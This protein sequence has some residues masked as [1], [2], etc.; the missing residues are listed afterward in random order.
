MDQ[1][2]S[3]YTFRLAASSEVSMIWQIFIDAIRKR[4][5]EGSEQWQDGY[6]NTNVIESDIEKG[7]GYVVIDPSGRLV[8]Y[9]ALIYDGEPAYELID[10]KWLTNRPYSVIHR[11]AVSQQPRIKGLATWMLSQAEQRSLQ[12]GYLSLKIDTNFDNT[13]ML[14]VLEKREYVYCGIVY[15][16]GGDRHAFEKMLDS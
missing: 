7:N 15:L 13:G 1:Q 8:G 6:P 14:R 5:E 3:D 12:A 2:F 11:L 10:K 4:K 16:R 9:L